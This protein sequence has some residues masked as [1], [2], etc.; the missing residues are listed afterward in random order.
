M[1]SGRAFFITSVAF[2][3]VVLNGALAR[4]EAPVNKSSQ[5]PFIGNAEAIAVGKVTFEA[6]CAGY[7]HATETTK[8]PGQC[9]NLFDCEWKHG[10]SDGEVFH[11]LSEGVPKT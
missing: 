7:C 4:A 2:G 10:K 3:L 9:P 11:S 8:R 1:Q 5:N 6:V